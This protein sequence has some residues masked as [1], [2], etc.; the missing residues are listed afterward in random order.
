MTIANSGLGEM[1]RELVLREALLA[2]DRRRADVE[3]QLD[4]S[5]FERADEGVD[6]S[7]LVADGANRLWPHVEA[8]SHHQEWTG[9]SK[10]QTGR[11]PGA[12]PG[13]LGRRFRRQ[14]KRRN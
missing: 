7:A 11:S 3:D 12:V 5:V 13:R 10:S 8:S 6:G 4:L 1:G 9:A 2:R 14:R